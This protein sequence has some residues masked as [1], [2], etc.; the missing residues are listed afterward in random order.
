MRN[1]WKIN[2]ILLFSILAISCDSSQRLN[3]FDLA[4]QY[5]NS[6]LDLD[7]Q[8][9]FGFEN[10]SISNLN[11]SFPSN[12]LLFVKNPNSEYIARYTVAYKVFSSYNEE[13]SIDSATIHYS[14]NQKKQTQKI[15]RKIKMFVPK[16]TNYVIQISV[17]DENR[18][19]TTT[20]FKSL[21]KKNENASNYFHVSSASN[22]QRGFYQNG[23]F[24]VGYHLH[25]DRTLKVLTFKRQSVIAPKPHDVNYNFHFLG[26]PDSVWL[27]KIKAGDSIEFPVLKNG[28]YHF[29]TD[30]LNKKGFSVFHINKDFPK[31]T[32]LKDATGAMGYLLHER[33]YANLL[34][35]KTPR[36]SFEWEWRKIAGGKERARNLIREYYKSVNTANQLFLSY[37]PGWS[38]DRGMIYIVYGPP[39]LVYRYDDGEVWVYGEENNL[40]SEVFNFKK[41][42]SSI[43]DNIYELERNINYKINWNR[44]VIAWK[45]DRG[46]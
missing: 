45:E 36:L 42:Q 24:K 28:F 40:M 43:S 38:T 4:P 30:T 17:S 31:T 3:Q 29:L 15:K 11:I 25:E 37:K 19:T 23:N 32:S 39:R 12:Q 33:D 22:K 2:I 14:L 1:T 18:N 13:T 10:D 9:F 41:V 27:V 44:M 46:F 20:Q 34:T 21:H 6:N 8:S 35:S 26:E 16:G 5:N 7:L